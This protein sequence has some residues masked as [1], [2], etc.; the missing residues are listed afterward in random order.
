METPV[1]SRQKR[2]DAL[3]IHYVNL[4]GEQLF[5]CYSQGCGNLEQT[6]LRHPVLH[7]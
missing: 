2:M 6:E 3:Y 5:A 1:N 7:I 4:N